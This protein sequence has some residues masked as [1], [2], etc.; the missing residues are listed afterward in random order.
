MMER[1]DCESSDD[2]TDCELD[3]LPDIKVNGSVSEREDASND[4]K[5]A[6]RLDG[7]L[8]QQLLDKSLTT[9]SSD[10]SIFKSDPK[11]F[12]VRRFYEL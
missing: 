8:Q 12:K 11:Q 4:G 2:A 5:E 3:P 1:T 10:S 7:S 6:V 9:I